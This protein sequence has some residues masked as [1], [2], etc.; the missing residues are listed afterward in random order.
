[1]SVCGILLAA[2]AGARLGAGRNKALLPLGGEALFLHALRALKPHCRNVILVVGEGEEEAFSRAMNAA[3]VSADTVLT[4]GAERRHSV[5]RALGK[6]PKDAD[7]LLVH[8]AARPFP[9]SRLIHSVLRAAGET[10]AAVPALPVDDTLR[11]KNGETTR[12]H[13]REGLYRV[14]TP[15]GFNRKLLEKAYAE[16]PDT[17]TDDA[18][19]VEK[20]GE[21]VAL[22]PGDPRN[23]K[24]TRREDLDLAER[25]LSG[26]LRAGTGY[27]AHRLV[28]GRALVLCGVDIPHETGLLGHSDADVALHALADALL[29]ACALGD[30]GAHFPDSREE[31]RG[32]SSL[33]L[34]EKT[35]ELIAE[36]GFIP[37]QC[38]L[39]IL[40]QRPR[41]APHILQMRRN[42]AQAL[43]LPLSRVSVK[44]TTTEGMGFEGR[45]EGISAQAAA[46]VRETEAPERWPAEG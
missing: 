19:L 11:E 5:E 3:G 26:C 16:N 25:L 18:G 15:Q 24:I 45:E 22:V 13:P 2:G 40:A 37:H 27:D 33:L 17:L 29:G 4:G 8:D 28:P 38:D 31:Y 9:T 1:M 35:R 42:I 6:L 39:T 41:L 36:K 43:G 14:Q 30:I 44:A 12:T 10:G 34:L 23:F 46:M 7:I 32:V 20:L 21:P